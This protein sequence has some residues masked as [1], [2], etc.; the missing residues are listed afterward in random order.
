MSTP[1]ATS[2]DAIRIVRTETDAALQ[3]LADT[4]SD[5]IDAL[6]EAVLD[7]DRVFLLGAGRSGLAL[8]MTAMRLMHLGL[9]VFV[10]GDTTTPAI[11]RGDLLLTATGSGTTTGIVRAATTARE[12]G[13]MVATI[14]TAPESPVAEL[15]RVVVAV[16]AAGKLDRSGAASAQYAGSLF[17]QTVVLLGDAL[18]HALWQR[19]G[20]SADDLWPR[21]SNLE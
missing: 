17:E 18:F 16:P 14:T 12:V 20:A 8:R 13:A 9:R 19:S 15:S 5:A 21:H 3:A 7:A 10:V 4:G 6:A 2:A 11:E 1:T